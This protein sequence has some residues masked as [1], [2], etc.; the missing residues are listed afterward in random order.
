MSSDRSAVVPGI[1][2]NIGKRIM[3]VSQG[4]E[5]R[6]PIKSLALPFLISSVHSRYVV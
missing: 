6:L 4:G 1:G 3:K 2:V 5:A